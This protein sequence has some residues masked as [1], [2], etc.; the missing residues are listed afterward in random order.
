MKLNQQD[1]LTANQVTDVKD[2]KKGFLYTKSD[3]IIVFLRLFP[4]NID[5]MSMQEKESKC[6]IL[7]AAFKGEKEPFSIISIPRTVDME[8][9][10]TSLSTKYDEEIF[11]PIKKMLLSTMISE[12]TKKVLD[13]QNFEHQFYLMIWEKYN[14][15]VIGIENKLLNRIRDF[16]NRYDAVNNITMILND[17]EIMRLCN[18]YANSNSAVFDQIGVT[19]IDY[20]AIP[21]I[22]GNHE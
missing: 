13:G 12:A 22:G 8:V 18:L 2:I 15:N 7:T 5:L 6:T 4:I 1:I 21:N 19:D 16:Q 11:N 17:S 9:Y 20:I 14:P 3:Y 10:L